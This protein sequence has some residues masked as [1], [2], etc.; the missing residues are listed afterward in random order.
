MNTP[1]V[2]AGIVAL[3]RAGDDGSL[4]DPFVMLFPITA[5]AVSTL[6]DP[7]GSEVVCAS[8]TT[9]ARLE[10]VQMDLGEGPS[11]EALRTGAPVLEP[12]LHAASSTRWSAAAI[13]MRG[14]SLASMSAFPMQVGVIKVGSVDLYRDRAGGLSP[15][16]VRDA[17]AM[18][19]IAS[20]L[21]LHRALLRAEAV[22]TEYEED[23]APY[24]RREVYQASGM[25]AAQTGATAADA[26]LLLRAHAYTAGRSV[27]SLS[28]DVIARIVDFSDDDSSPRSEGNQP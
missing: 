6:G 23:A 19:A 21:V 17:T 7:L 15:S 22:D 28:A 24:S 14:T 12:D 13:A 27:R 3:G 16:A 26:M 5:A 8:S 4:C 1:R 10:E 9:A 2:A 11:W 25:L 18:V 20:R